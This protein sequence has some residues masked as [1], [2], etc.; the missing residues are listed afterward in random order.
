[1]TRSSARRYL[2]MSV[3][4]GRDQVT[5]LLD[6]AER[7]GHAAALVDEADRK[8]GL[9]DVRAEVTFAGG[10][11]EVS[12]PGFSHGIFY[13]YLDDLHPVECTLDGCQCRH[14]RHNG[15]SSVL[16][17]DPPE[18]CRCTHPSFRHRFRTVRES[19]EECRQPANWMALEGADR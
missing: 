4:L 2:I 11:Y 5:A 19:I 9:T 17:G 18:T 16:V 7:T 1:M 8:P 10:A 12:R 15:R 14:Y 6:E 13:N 3:R